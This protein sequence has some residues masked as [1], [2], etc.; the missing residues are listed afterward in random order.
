MK[1]R[2]L[3]SALLAVVMISAM[4]PVQALAALDPP[5]LVPVP[6][7]FG[8]DHGA[9]A[10]ESASASEN[11]GAR[12]LWTYEGSAFLAIQ[13]RKQ[14]NLEWVKIDETTYDE[15]NST[16]HALA[17]KVSFKI[18]QNIYEPD[19]NCK[20]TIVEMEG[21]SF[22]E[23][24][25]LTVNSDKGTGSDVLGSVSVKN[26]ADAMTL[27]V[28][29]TY[30]EN[31]ARLRQIYAYKQ[32]GSVQVGVGLRTIVGYAFDKAYFEG[33]RIEDKDGILRVN[34]NRGN[35]YRVDFRYTVAPIAETFF[36]D[37]YL[38]N[39]AIYMAE[40]PVTGQGVSS[41][42]GTDKN[43]LVSALESFVYMPKNRYA[44]FAAQSVACQDNSGDYKPAD[45]TTAEDGALTFSNPLS[46][47]PGTRVRVDYVTLFEISGA[48]TGAAEGVDGK[49]AVSPTHVTRG[50]ASTVTMQTKEGYTVDS[51]I[52]NGQTVTP[53]KTADRTWAVE[54][55]NIQ[56]NQTVTANIAVI[57]SVPATVEY[58]ANREGSDESIKFVAFT[59]GGYATHYI[60]HFSEDVFHNFAADGY[61]FE[62]WSTSPM[63]NQAEG[64]CDLPGG[65]VILKAGETLHLYAHWSTPVT[66][67]YYKDSVQAQTNRIGVRDPEGNKF[68]PKG[69]NKITDSQYEAISIPLEIGY[70][71]KFQKGDEGYGAAELISYFGAKS[72]AALPMFYSVSRN[73]TYLQ[74][75]TQDYAD[76][77][78]GVRVNRRAYL[79]EQPDV[80]GNAD[81][82]KY[83][84]P[85]DVVHIEYGP[86][87]GAFR[88]Y[89]TPLTG[90]TPDPISDAENIGHQVP[91]SSLGLNE[92]IANY[93]LPEGADALREVYLERQVI[94][95]ETG[96]AEWDGSPNNRLDAVR[97]DDGAFSFS[98]GQ[99]EGWTGHAHCEIRMVFVYCVRENDAIYASPK[100]TYRY[101]SQ[102]G[103]S[104][105]AWETILAGMTKLGDKE[106]LRAGDNVVYEFKML[107]VGS[108][109]MTDMKVIDEL[110]VGA[111]EHTVETAKYGWHVK[112]T[113][114][115]GKPDPINTVDHSAKDEGYVKVSLAPGSY[116]TIY[117]PYT[118][119]EDDVKNPQ[120]RLWSQYVA[121]WQNNVTG[122][123]GQF[124]SL[125]HIDRLEAPQ[126]VSLN[127]FAEELMPGGMSTQF[128]PMTDDKGEPVT[129]EVA[130]GY[131]LEKLS[132]EEIAQ[133][134]EKAAGLLNQQSH[135]AL[136][137]SYLT[138]E[139]DKWQS[140]DENVFA[141]GYSLPSG[142]LQIGVGFALNRREII[143]RL[144]ENANGTLI[145]E[146]AG[147]L[148]EDGNVSYKIP[149]GAT[150]G[151]WYANSVFAPKAEPKNGFAFA[152]W[153]PEDE[154]IAFEA[155]SGTKI[156]RNQAY[157]ASWA[158]G[159][160]PYTVVYHKTDDPG[161]RYQ[162]QG[163][164]SG[165]S[166]IVKLNSASLPNAPV[167][168]KFS[169][170]AFT[171]KNDN[172]SFE[173]TR[174][175]SVINVYFQPW[176]VSVWHRLGTDGAAVFDAAQSIENLS[177]APSRD[178]VADASKISTS[179]R[180]RYDYTLYQAGSG[181]P[182]TLQNAPAIASGQLTPDSSYKIIFVYY[183]RS[184][185]GG[186]NSGN[187]NNGNGGDG[188]Q[189]IE[190]P[191]VPL[192]GLDAGDHF[193]YMFGY[194]DGTIRPEANI[195]RE[196]VVSIFY[197]LLN[198]ASRTLYSTNEQN[199]GDVEPDRWS[200]KAIATM[201]NA[202][203]VTGY[204]GGR[205]APGNYITRAEFA[206]VVSNFDNLTYVGENKFNDISGHWAADAI[207][208]ASEKG[209]ITGYEDG[210]FRPDQYITRAEAMSLINRV[211]KR[212][213]SA[214]GLSQQARGWPDN[215]VGA[216]YYYDVLEATNNHDYAE[217][218]DPSQSEKWTQVK[219]DMTWD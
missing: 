151:Q 168:Y 141:D 56:E 142:S 213:V 37:Y 167:G 45:F 94:N 91:V 42:P 169:R 206:V 46:L 17:E 214:D 198:Q 100:T 64:Y 58:H 34:L 39:A 125:P 30:G 80:Y 133:A 95:S 180:I 123:F 184:S 191:E 154:S 117:V 57:A 65:S 152:G 6:V 68:V 164:V 40:L 53:A 23:T 136:P 166:N 90:I 15:Q 12:W 120:K 49:P 88:M 5:D 174:D 216:W 173:I 219:P 178:I 175:H 148:D 177:A 87:S 41:L 207:N 13:T 14:H 50:G 51:V 134:I 143:Y 155:L 187:G 110:Y 172:S 204:P 203:I 76:F 69:T 24:F 147:E 61:H 71:Y 92:K 115:D 21:P 43:D 149:Y 128:V 81:T 211:L 144:G 200:N 170:F 77:A 153:I 104:D 55:T 140:H 62:H 11:T 197:R 201:A 85:G 9:A 209:W 210:S 93:E 159:G 112:L 137:H 67:K 145:P 129:I 132:A 86:E 106:L 146:G 25:T 52:V 22:G 111:D 82:L 188:L 32:E 1:I 171:G 74:R 75:R 131:D 44:G 60:P 48:Y 36:V 208:S 161:Y 215:P 193:N 127:V 113:S 190:E 3:L 126:T 96:K 98:D 103:W 102:D 135:S 109:P 202:S 107:N 38:D 192:A 16:F 176:D 185:G 218:T 4:L 101:G 31:A 212:A 194:P 121:D 186:G 182:Q 156:T 122:S 158:A 195:T 63:P 2:R 165:A 89:Q 163:S 179:S 205:F 217:R 114:V 19:E 79:L 35:T 18:N 130:R 150:P 157:T 99:L 54:L 84:R 138:W 10:L 8:S 183:H 83:V 124:S 28:Y 181:A 97:A 162:T 118:V 105:R 29:D 59:E 72:L 26:M 196:E 189:N 73:Q 7:D 108:E 27:F 139:N 66:V 160:L 78:E 199:F 33:A 119:T 116:A 20:W 70:R 47:K